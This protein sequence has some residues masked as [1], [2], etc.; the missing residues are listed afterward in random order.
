MKRV[1]IAMSG[2][3]DSSV[4]AVLLQKSGYEVIGGTME[5]FP[6]YE[7]PS[8]EE[9]GCC[10]LSSIEDARRVA[11]KIDIPHYTLN[12]KEVFQEKVI[13][14][15]V[16]EYSRARTPNPCV[17]C[18]NEIKFKSL[19][20]K[21]LEID[22]DYIATGHYAV[23]E[24]NS[25]AGQRHLLKKA[26]DKYKDQTYM[27]YGLNQFQLAHTLMPLGDYI[28]KEVRNMAREWGLRIYNKKE[29]QE[30]CFV[31]DDDY[32]RFLDDNYTE[33]S[34]PGLILDLEGNKLGEHRGLHYYTIGQRRGLGISLPYPVYV[35]KLDRERNAV[36]VGRDESVFSKG[37]IA[38]QL[39]WIAVEKLKEPR[40]LSVKIRYNS[41]EVVGTIYPAEEDT[42]RIL[43]TEKQR[44]VT[45]GQSVVF[46]DKDLVIGGG[47]IRESID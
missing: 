46:Y 35:V 31:P 22:C 7:Q 40:E 16:Q 37:L 4:A 33:L 26:V 30:I 11:H 42:V 28:K 41:P 43:F 1:M 17:I 24:H 15:F 34:E 27:L 10:S 25:G 3:V 36:V 9:G 29:S 5:I 32:V 23:I 6:D 8:E 18:N 13:D 19:L 45:P 39:N 21:A 14:N 2:G 38:E 44:A 47:I 12:L 20:K